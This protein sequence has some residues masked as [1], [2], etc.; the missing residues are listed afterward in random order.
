VTSQLPE[1]VRPSHHDLRA[2]D[3]DRQLVADVLNT[4]YADGRITLD[5]LNER[6][7]VTWRART[8]GELVPVTADLMPVARHD[9]YVSPT[10]SRPLV[11]PTTT[12]TTDSFTSIMSTAR[13][14]G[15]WRVSRRISG[16]VIMGDAK[17]DLRQATFDAERCELNISCIMGDVKI[18]VPEG[19]SVRDETSAIMGDHKLSGVR[20]ET[21]GGPLLVVRGFILM[22]DLTVYGPD[23]VSL[24]K[25]LGLT[26]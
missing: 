26:D 15:P 25:R 17:I 2:A 24:G 7:D 11:D 23:H 1:P 6:L 21:S 22:G 9:Q 16:T 19:V 3:T 4:A 5:E 13:R 8:F 14:Q 20:A 18:W 12:N 10:P